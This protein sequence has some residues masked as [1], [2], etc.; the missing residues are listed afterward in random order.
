MSPRR[1]PDAHDARVPPF[2]LAT[3][4]RRIRRRA[5][6][7]QRELAAALGTAASVIAQAETRR[8]DLPVSH[9]LRAAELAGLRV[10]LLD[11]GGAE[12]PPMSA[13]PVRDGAGRRFPAH[14]DTRYGDEGWWHGPER[15]SR[16]RP[17]YTF[18]RNREFRDDRRRRTGVPPEHL[19]PQP[20]DPLAERAAER[21]QAARR[22]QNERRQ[23]RLEET[24]AAE[25]S[26]DLDW[27]TGCTCPAGCE[28]AEGR[29]EDLSH[30]SSCACRCDVC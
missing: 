14:L 1:I 16:R 13:D 30:A 3:A 24:R 12:V 25:G 20:G 26:V 8:R 23:R 6:L 2:D 21:R 17:T 27:G 7:S 11:A 4:L 29:N 22:R 15:Y 19:Q 10:A 18:D 28:L 9:L 5:D